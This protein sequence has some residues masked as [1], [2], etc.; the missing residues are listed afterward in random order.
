MWIEKLIIT[1][2]S[3]FIHEGATQTFC[4]VVD[5]FTNEVLY[6][7]GVYVNERGREFTGIGHC[8]YVMYVLLEMVVGTKINKEKLDKIEVLHIQDKITWSDK[9]N[10]IEL[11]CKL[12]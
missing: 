6:I 1:W 10:I 2:E 7:D 8:E 11:L 9:M 3:T 4:L 12:Y 5:E